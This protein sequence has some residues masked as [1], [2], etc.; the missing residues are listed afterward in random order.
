MEAGVSVIICTYN[1]A[2]LLPDTLR[3]LARQNVPPE[4]P[5]EVIVI[6]NASTDQS[7]AV[8]ASVWEN[9]GNKTPFSL[10]HQPQP[11]LTFARELGLAKARYEFVLFCDD[12]NWLC[13]DYVK[14][15]YELMMQH[16]E[17]GM[18]GGYGELVFQEKPP[19]WARNSRLFASGPQA[20]RSGKVKTNVV[21]GAGSVMRRTAFEALLKAGFRSRLTD[22]KGASLSSG[23]DYEL[24]FAL[25]LAGNAIWYHDRLIFRHFIPAK[26][27]TREYHERYFRE[28][29]QSFSA[30]V[31]YRF[32]VNKGSR[33]LADFHFQYAKTVA[34]YTRK[35]LP[36]F[37]KSLLL[38]AGLR[39]SQAN[40]LAY[41]SLKAKLGS[42]RNYRTMLQ[43]FRELLLF[44]QQFQDQAK[45]QFLQVNPKVN[46]LSQSLR[47]SD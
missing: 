23:G 45:S 6:D 20:L 35:L 26:R 37:I 30:L 34:N 41:I 29:A 39:T 7:A 46:M 33:S 14:R 21:Y 42:F 25:A 4:I 16:P 38:P 44:K 15:A 17:I 9:S 1:G 3:H 8:A 22:R 5:W 32:L 19:H 24:C 12:D 10:L 27:L 2:A 36:A 43:N 11:G 31:P 28:S 18:L 40:E 13:P 47:I